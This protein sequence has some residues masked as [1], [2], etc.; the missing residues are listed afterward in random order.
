[1]N[2]SR[3]L[4]DSEPNPHGRHR[5]PSDVTWTTTSIVP[6]GGDI[7]VVPNPYFKNLDGI[8]R[9]RKRLGR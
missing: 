7:T 8:A 9:L 5:H 1:M 4:P 3:S 6:H 2:P